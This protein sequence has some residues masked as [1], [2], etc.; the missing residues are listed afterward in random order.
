MQGL[1]CQSDKTLS[2]E[3]YASRNGHVTSLRFISLLLTS[4]LWSCYV[5]LGTAGPYKPKCL[6]P[7]IF[8][9]GETP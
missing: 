7:Y 2:I 8:L 1:I 3:N 9:H 6:S 4:F 5:S